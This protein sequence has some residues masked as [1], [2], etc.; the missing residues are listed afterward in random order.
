MRLLTILFAL[1][2]SLFASEADAIIKALEDNLRGES[3]YMKMTMKVMSKR[4]ERTVK[5]ES[6]AQGKKKSFMKI[7]Y[8]NKDKGITFLKIDAQMWQY[9]PKIER[10]IKIPSSMM[11]QSWMG[12]DFTNDDMVKESS[13][14][15]DYNAELIDRNATTA[16][17]RLIPKP[18]APVVWGKIISTVDITQSVPLHEE[19]YDDRMEKVRIMRYSDVRQIGTHR[20]PMHMELKPLDPDKKKN[21]TVVI[22]DEAE[23]DGEISDAYFSKQALKRYSR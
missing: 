22:I 10:I 11:M 12:S 18:D 8:P 4:G 13:I 2:T 21:K 23:F 5:I 17:I 7:L 16:T 14:V 6:W 15:D 20:F 19:F 1:T 3:A 9:I